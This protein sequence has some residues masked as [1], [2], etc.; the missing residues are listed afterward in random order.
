MGSVPT[1]TDLRLHEQVRLIPD[2][3]NVQVTGFVDTP[4]FLQFNN[5][6]SPGAKDLPLN[7]YEAALSEAKDTDAGGKFVK[8]EF[9]V[10]TGEAERIA[11]DGATRGGMGAQEDDQGALYIGSMLNVNSRRK[12][13]HA[14][15]RHPHAVR[16]DR[17]AFDI[18]QIGL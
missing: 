15:Q 16:E 18:R 7:L 9:G 2:R 1:P 17:S 4:I 8:L 5:E 11:V 12:P 14:T 3:A 13:R 10:E 6:P